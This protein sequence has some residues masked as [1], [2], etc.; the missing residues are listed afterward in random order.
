MARPTTLYRAPKGATLMIGPRLT[1]EEIAAGTPPLLREAGR[2]LDCSATMAADAVIRKEWAE[3]ACT[4]AEEKR[5]YPEKDVAI[6]VSLRSAADVN[7]IILAWQGGSKVETGST[8]VPDEATRDDI[9]TGDVHILAL[10]SDGTATITDSE[11]TPAEA[12][13]GTNWE[14]MNGSA[15]VIRILDVSALTLPLLITYDTAPSTEIGVMN[16]MGVGRYLAVQATNAENNCS[17]EL[18]EFYNA[19]PDGD[20]EDILGIA[21]DATDET[22]LT[23]TFTASAHPG[24]P[25]D[26]V[27]GTT[28][29]IIR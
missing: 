3:Q 23:M 7:N 27:L 6:S 1:D 17:Q 2:M 21:P 19:T 28:G 13:Q 18:A 9:T 20:F 25:A 11:G 22:P 24:M 8:A 5:T 16:A 4:A 15:Q 26:P 14:W 12:V 29:R 10:M